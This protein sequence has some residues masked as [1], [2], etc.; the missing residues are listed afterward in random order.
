MFGWFKK[1][2]VDYTGY[3]NHAEVSATVSELRKKMVQSEA[4]RQDY[5][6]TARLTPEQIDNVVMWLN[7]WEQ[8]K[9]TAIPIRFKEDFSK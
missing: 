9:D 7:T 8:L 4:W 1:K 2:P 6:F 3:V 5:D